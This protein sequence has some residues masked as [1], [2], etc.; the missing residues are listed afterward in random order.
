MTAV[1]WVVKPVSQMHLAPGSAVTIPN[2]S[3]SEF[4]SILQEMGEKRAARVA[5]SKG[6]LEIMVPL[7]EH[8]VPRD[9]I[10]DIVKTLLKA[11]GRRY[12]PFGSTTF[13]EENTAGVEPDA[14]FY[15]QNYQRMIGHRRLKPDD[16]PPD[17]AIETDVTSKTTLGAYS[18]IAVPELWLYDSGKLTIYLL[19]DGK[20]INSDLSPTFPNIPL[21]QIIPAVVERAWQ[22][23][24]VQALEEFENSLAVQFLTATGKNFSE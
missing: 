20:Y 3:W 16:P 18:A 14:C 9:L 13:K 11:S 7:P 15:I 24:S 6:S 2:V 22:V 19:R 4:E 17:L 21:T 10:S 23:G 1:S 8:E 12:Q 5:Y